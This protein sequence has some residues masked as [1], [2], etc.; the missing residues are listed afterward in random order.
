MFLDYA[1]RIDMFRVGL[2]PTSPAG[3]NVKFKA[4]DQSIVGILL[5]Y[6][7]VN[8]TGK[9]TVQNSPVAKVYIQ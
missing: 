8:I 9:F 6:P 4:P 1:V 2:A 5:F 7:I 3:F